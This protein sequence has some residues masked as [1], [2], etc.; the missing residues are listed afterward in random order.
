MSIGTIGAINDWV[1]APAAQNVSAQ[2][3]PTTA[4]D[5]TA[6]SGS[7]SSG[8]STGSAAI[9]QA[10]TDASDSPTSQLLSD[11]YG[12]STDTATS[13]SLASIAA[14]SALWHGIDQLV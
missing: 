7:T 11:L 14:E 5:E 4:T 13:S 3:D 10:E 8:A 1:T 2:A 9:E 6:A 12:S